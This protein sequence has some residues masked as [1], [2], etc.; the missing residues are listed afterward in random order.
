MEGDL[1]SYCIDTT[2]IIKPNERKKKLGE[3]GFD[4]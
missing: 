2:M 4:S 1:V 3:E